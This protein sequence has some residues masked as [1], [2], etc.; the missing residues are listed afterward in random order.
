MLAALVSRCQHEVVDV[1][2]S[3]LEAIHA[4][5]RHKP[6]VVLM[7]HWMSRLNGVTACRNIL[8]KDPAARIILISGVDRAAEPLDAGAIAVLRKPVTLARLDEALNTAAR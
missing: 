3:G 4:Y 7:D 2:A 6:D 8:A 1:V 5:E